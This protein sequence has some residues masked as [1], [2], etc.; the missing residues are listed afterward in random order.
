MRIL[1]YLP[2]IDRSS[3]GV[4][5]YIQ[6]LSSALEGRAELHLL[7][8]HTDNEVHVDNCIVHYLSVRY[9]P[10]WNTRGEF[11][12]ILH[13]VNPD[14]FHTNSCWIPTSSMTAIWAK[15]AGCK[16]VYTPHGMLEPWILKRNYWTKKFPALLLFQKRALKKSDMIHATSEN[17]MKNILTLGINNNVCIVPNAI[18]VDSVKMKLSWE[19]RRSILYLGRLHEKKGLLHLFEA[20]SELKNEAI[21]NG[22]D[23]PYHIDIVGDSDIEQPNYKDIL[24]EK[25]RSLDLSDCI[26]FH[27]G[28]YD[29]KK[30]DWFRNADVFVLPTYSEN[31]G[32]VV[33]ESLAAGTPVITTQ[34]APWSCLQSE[35]CGWWIGTGT[36]PLKC[37]L[38]DFMSMSADDLQRMG[39]SGRRVVEERFGKDVIGDEYIE[40][41]KWVLLAEKEK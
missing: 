23:F 30:W 5:T 38:S 22:K 41:Y 40:M 39:M 2:D 26:Y 17:E 35:K 15:K 32:I 24:T 1:H 34:G 21:N 4:L 12:R 10:K 7:T 9:V 13:E 28:V 37:A 19:N 25:V 14:V 29:D 20:F 27:D 11:L 8:C 16:V 18:D 31:F 36:T 6:V 33:A 3:G